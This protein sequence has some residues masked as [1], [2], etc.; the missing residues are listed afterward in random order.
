[1]LAV[2][3]IEKLC[4]DLTAL[5][6]VTNPE[7]KPHFQFIYLI[8]DLKLTMVFAGTCE[9]SSRDIRINKTIEFEQIRTV[10]LDAAFSSMED[11]IK[12]WM[13]HGKDIA[14]KDEKRGF[15][16]KSSSLKTILFGKDE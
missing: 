8:E 6:T 15:T 5:G 12:K 7:D 9:K 10:N 13:A 11:D 1:M 3:R 14:I 2:S 16:I 4:D